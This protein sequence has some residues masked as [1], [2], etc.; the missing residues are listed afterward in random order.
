MSSFEIWPHIASGVYILCFID[1]RLILVA[2]GEREI[3]SRG[4]AGVGD[5][6][7]LLLRSTM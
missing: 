5:V 7:S 3:G 2:F 1:T 4:V 6:E